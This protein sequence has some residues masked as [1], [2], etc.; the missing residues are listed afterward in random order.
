M[1]W[2]HYLIIYVIA[3]YLITPFALRWLYKRE[4]KKVINDSD[5]DTVAGIWVF[6][7]LLIWLVVA[8]FVVE[9]VFAPIDT[10][11]KKEEEL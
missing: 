10:K 5:R 8:G 11:P 4:N 2:Y 6:S 9:F 1:Y 7:P 3:T